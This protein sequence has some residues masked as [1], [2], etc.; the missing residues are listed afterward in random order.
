MSDMVPHLP[1]LLADLKDIVM[2]RG[3]DDIMRDGF[4]EV[5]DRLPPLQ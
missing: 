5:I 2:T 4:R 1:G 3:F